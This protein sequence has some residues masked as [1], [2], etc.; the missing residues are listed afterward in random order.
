M[1][2]RLSEA[3][4]RDLTEIVTYI[5][6]DNPAAAER[7]FVDFGLRFDL[8]A[9]RPRLGRSRPEIGAG[10]RSLPVGRYLI[11]YRIGRDAVEIARVVHG[12]QSVRYRDVTRER[13]PERMATSPR[14]G[15]LADRQLPRPT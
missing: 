7:M 12:A 15:I 2:Y 6:Q 11:F 3:A 4:E 5:A 14:I 10:V 8:L 1:T 13:S 9:Q